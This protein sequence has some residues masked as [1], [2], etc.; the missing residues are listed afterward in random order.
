MHPLAGQ[1]MNLGIADAA[2]LAEVVHRAYEGGQDIGA[3]Q[4]LG[5]FSRTRQMNNLMMLLTTDGLYRLFHT[6]MWPVPALR[7]VGLRALDRL[8]PLKV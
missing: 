1:N 6:Q 4:L 7:S 8:Q 2:H 3:S 5:G